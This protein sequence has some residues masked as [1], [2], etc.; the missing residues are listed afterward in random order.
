MK[1]CSAK[2]KANERHTLTGVW[3]EITI[4]ADRYEGDEVTPSRVCELKWHSQRVSAAQ[5]GHTLTGVWVEM[6]L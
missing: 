1:I 3:V 4:T 5:A 2:E 6:N